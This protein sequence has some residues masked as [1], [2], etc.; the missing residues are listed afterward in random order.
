[1]IAH[2]ESRKH[3]RR[4]VIR[5]RSGTER[6]LKLFPQRPDLPVCN[7]RADK[8]YDTLKRK[9][10]QLLD[11]EGF[12]TKTMALNS[13][14]GYSRAEKIAAYEKHIAAIAGELGLTWITVNKHTQ[15]E[16]GITGVKSGCH[17]W[18][19]KQVHRRAQDQHEKQ[20]Q[21]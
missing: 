8:L 19:R 13:L 17:A 7:A 21:S 1:M 2:K 6:M 5:R 12:F 11:Y 3:M 10:E 20:N 4:D 18:V 15:K 14:H 16:R 9:M